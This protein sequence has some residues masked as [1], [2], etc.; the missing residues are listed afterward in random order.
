MEKIK[1]VIENFKSSFKKGE[2][3]RK[4]IM[5]KILSLAAAFCIWF[6]VVSVESPVIEKTFYDIPVQVMLAAD[7]EL[8]PFSGDDETVDVTVRGKRSALR[9]ID[10]DDIDA[11]LDVSKYTEA[12]EYNVRVDIETP[13]SATLVEQ[14][15]TE[16]KVF[17]DSYASKTLDI[18]VRAINTSIDPNV[19][20]VW[21]CEPEGVTISGPESVISE[22]SKAQVD[23]DCKKNSEAQMN[24]D[25]NAVL[26]DNDDSVVKSSYLKYIKYDPKVYVEMDT[27][28]T[29]YV[30]LRL[31]INDLEDGE[32]SYELL[33]GTDQVTQIPIKGP[34]DTVNNLSEIVIERSYKD[35]LKCDIPLPDTVTMT[36]GQPTEITAKVTL[37]YNRKLLE[38]I[39]IAVN[40]PEN[41]SYK[42][43]TNTVD[44]SIDYIP[45]HFETLKAEDVRA[46]LDLKSDSVSGKYILTPKIEGVG[47]D[48]KFIVFDDVEVYVDITNEQ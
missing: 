27:I 41:I 4:T 28:K 44:F 35:E 30:D 5:P 37:N 2:D 43:S 17:L 39:P 24:R 45:S 20:L 19:D 10:E 34:L 26:L 48:N 31:D 22:V 11:L 46:V 12:G 29:K 6:Y 18:D 38:S 1:N 14:S 25:L 36:E 15:I 23:F 21:Q 33:N 42:L 8:E 7:G 13:S 3:S 32:Y 16:V 40:A 9:G 47:P